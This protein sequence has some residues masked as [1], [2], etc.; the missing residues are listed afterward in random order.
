MVNVWETPHKLQHREEQCN[1]CDCTLISLNA[2]V[3]TKLQEG[4]KE[5]HRLLGTL[6]MAPSR[7]YPT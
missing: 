7:Q 3:I 1:M 4:S 2:K 5:S 6:N